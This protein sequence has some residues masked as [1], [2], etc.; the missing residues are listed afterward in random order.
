MHATS[1]LCNEQ[2]ECWL[3]DDSLLNHVDSL[4]PSFFP[5]LFKI[6]TN[7]QKRRSTN[8][9][10][11]QDRFRPKCTSTHF[12]TDKRFWKIQFDNRHHDSSIWRDEQKCK[13]NKPNPKPKPKELTRKIVKL[14]RHSL[15]KVPRSRWS[16]SN[17]FNQE[18]QCVFVFEHTL[19][20]W[21]KANRSTAN[22]FAGILDTI[23][24]CIF[25]HSM[26]N[27]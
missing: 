14:A 5:P 11:D 2:I 1:F 16:G 22:R 3:T 18:R 4:T 26:V 27:R 25:L 13:L 19:T 9:D 23:R 12:K 24:C 6:A 10:F 17:R 15:Q 21:A 7:C 20:C 8:S